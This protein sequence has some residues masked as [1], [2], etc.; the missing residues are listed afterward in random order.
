[1]EKWDAEWLAVVDVNRTP[2]STESQ[3]ENGFG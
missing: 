3:K 1:M 2:T